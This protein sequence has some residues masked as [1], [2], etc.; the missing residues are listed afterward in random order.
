LSNAWSYS[1]YLPVYW[2]YRHFTMIGPRTYARN[3]IVAASAVDVEGCVVECGVWRGGMSAGLAHVFGPRR[4]YFLFDS[5]E[6]LPP[7]TDMDGDAARRWQADTASPFYYDNCSAGMR[8]AHEAMS[9]SPA[10]RF[11]LIKGWFADTVAGFTPPAPIALLRLDG[12]WY[13]STLCCLR[14]LYPHVADGGVVVFD[15]YYAWDGCARAVHEYLA[16]IKTAARIE[17][18]FDPICVVRK[19]GSG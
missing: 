13:E 1:R 2:R 6:G 17:Q 18:P 19:R 4:E 15:D 11:N 12:D 3:L 14:A 7:P 9:R 16:E 5:F 10:R 8:E